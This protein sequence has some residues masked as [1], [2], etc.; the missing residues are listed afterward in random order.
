M[1]GLNQPAADWKDRIGAS[2]PPYMVPSE[3]LLAPDLP[4][5]TNGKIDRKALEQIYLTQSR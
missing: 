4:V 1:P 5:S 3:L 2:L